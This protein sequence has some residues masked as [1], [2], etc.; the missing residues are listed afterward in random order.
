MSFHADN[1]TTSELHQSHKFSYMPWKRMLVQFV[2]KIL[3]YNLE[4]IKLVS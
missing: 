4:G 3:Q 2:T 1:E